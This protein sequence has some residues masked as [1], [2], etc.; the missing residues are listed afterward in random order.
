MNP[1]ATLQKCNE[2]IALAEEMVTR[3]HGVYLKGLHAFL[4]KPIPGVYEAVVQAHELYLDALR[5]LI[6]LEVQRDVMFIDHGIGREAYAPRTGT[7]N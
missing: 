7:E 3:A 5:R 4:A 1:N 6:R 2:V